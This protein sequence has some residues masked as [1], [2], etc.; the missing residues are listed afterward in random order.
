MGD[1]TSEKNQ[2]GGS[3]ARNYAFSFLR[4]KRML[5]DGIIDDTIN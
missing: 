1:S 4:V 2:R 5:L 3:K